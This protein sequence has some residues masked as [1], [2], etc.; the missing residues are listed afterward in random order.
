MIRVPRE[1]EHVALMAQEESDGRSL[2]QPWPMEVVE[3]EGH[4]E[5]TVVDTCTK[6]SSPQ[7]K[8]RERGGGGGEVLVLFYLLT[9]M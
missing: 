7:V 9:H 3:G 5:T 1:E 6:S 8:E 4:G 2:Y